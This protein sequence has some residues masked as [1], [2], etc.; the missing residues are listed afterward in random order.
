MPSGEV[1][2]TLELLAIAQKLVPF[3]AT[4]YQGL[5]LGRVRA[6]HVTPSDEVSAIAVPYRTVQNKVP[7]AASP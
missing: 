5:L 3:Q 4:L 1:A 2:A 7:L 6:V